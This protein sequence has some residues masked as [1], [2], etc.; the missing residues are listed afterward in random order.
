MP[1]FETFVVEWSRAEDEEPPRSEMCPRALAGGGDGAGC[2]SPSARRAAAASAVRNNSPRA[3][4]RTRAR[5]GVDPALGATLGVTLGLTLLNGFVAAVEPRTAEER[6]IRVGDKFVSV[7]GV[8][9]AE[10]SDCDIIRA[11]QGKQSVA[12]AFS[13]SHAFTPRA[14]FGSGGCSVCGRAR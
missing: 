7:D 2:M 1:A 3:R 11:I 8:S 4:G 12:V 13:R 14:F 5:L 9:V 10:H 6:G